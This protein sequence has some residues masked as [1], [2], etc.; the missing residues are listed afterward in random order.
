MQT[1]SFFGHSVS[2]LILGDNPMTGH[3]Y[4]E[5]R[6]TGREMLAFYTAETIKK[7]LFEAEALGYSAMLPLA[8]PYMIR[9]LKEYRRDGGRLQFIF[10]PY[11]PMDQDVSMRQMAELEPIG[12]YHQGTTTD[13]LFESGR[14]PEI[15]ARMEQYRALGI[16]VGLGT[17]RP[18]VIET[19]ER[20]GWPADFYL[21][22][23]QNARRGRERTQS[24][25]LTGQTKQGLLFYPEDR[26]VM[27]QLLSGV[28]KPVIAFKIFA[29]GQML[30]GL[31][32]CARQQKILN[33]YDEVF[34]S[35]KPDD[36]AVAGVFQRDRDQLRENAEL[37]ARWEARS[38]RNDCQPP[39]EG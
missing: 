38:S 35:L 5:H 25:F 19:S 4:I 30:D 2:R 3:S 10:Q 9:V 12:I 22:C 8:D 17:H 24:G 36:L 18:D 37:F 6:I 39:A 26:P 11:M 33:V 34:S 32:D 1:V 29:G 31:E 27:L 21:A 13:F 15:L 20:E 14:T 23:L 16:P 7:T 28:S